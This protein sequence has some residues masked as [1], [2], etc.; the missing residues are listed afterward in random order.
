MAQDIFNRATPA[1][2]EIQMRGAGAVSNM[3]R[4]NPILFRRSVVEKIRRTARFEEFISP[5]QTGERV[6]LWDLKLRPL[7]TLALMLPNDTLRKLRLVSHATSAAMALFMPRLFGEI[8]MYHEI[9]SSEP[10]KSLEALESVGAY[11]RELVITLSPATDYAVEEPSSGLPGAS[12]GALDVFE[13]QKDFPGS[14]AHTTDPQLRPRY[15]E[16]TSKATTSQWVSQKPNSL[17][18]Y[19]NKDVASHIHPALRNASPSENSSASP[20]ALEEPSLWTYIF[21]RMPNFIAL[22]IA[23]TVEDMSWHPLGPIEK[24]LVSLRNALEKSCGDRSLQTINRLHTLRLAPITAMSI[25]PLRWAGLAALSTSGY[26]EWWTSFF[27][28]SLTV[29]EI[30]IASPYSTFSTSESR[31]F[32]KILH[33][34]LSSFTDTLK[35]LRFVWLG[36]VGPNPMLLDLEAQL[37]PGKPGRRSLKDFSAPAIVWKELKEVWLGGVPVGP[38]TGATMIS[39][40]EKLKQIMLLHENHW[41]DLEPGQVWDLED[42]KGWYDVFGE[43]GELGVNEAAALVEIEKYREAVWD[44]S[45]QHRDADV[46]DGIEGK[47]RSGRETEDWETGAVDEP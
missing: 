2:D 1:R 40:A 10:I 19:R 42:P 11:C 26:S 21:R 18:L 22:T 27:W 29:L 6:D 3:A 4:V 23:I 32:G 8:H 38:F 39:R 43:C 41:M 33:D 17:S 9:D 34:Y 35:V 7:V 28:S 5:F 31:M 37:R 30:Q 12:R 16:P 20:E 24:G 46:D 13:D 15:T 47:G 25:L 36:G 44:E 45:G 14:K